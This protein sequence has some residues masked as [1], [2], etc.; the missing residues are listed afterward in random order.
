MTQR[1]LERDVEAKFLS[2]CYELGIKC[3]KLRLASESGWPDR[4][5]LYKGHVMFMELKR[6]GER[7]TALQMYTLDELKKDGFDARWSNDFE[8]MKLIVLSWAKHVDSIR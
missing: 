3:R 8:H 4:T 7:P 6:S 1:P 5:L 2:F